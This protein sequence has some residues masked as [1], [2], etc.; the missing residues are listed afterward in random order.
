MDQFCTGLDMANLRGLIER[1][2]KAGA[3]VIYVQHD[4]GRGDSLESGT[5]GW[6]IHEAVAPGAG[7]PVIEKR[8]PDSFH[9]TGLSDLLQSLGVRRLV[10]TGLQTE[11]CVDTTCRRAF[12]LGFE[13]VLVEDGHSTCDSAYLDAETIVRH[14]NNVLRGFFVTL[15]PAEKVAF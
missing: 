15:A 14:H 6:R 2:E 8:T 7:V 10:V 13:V 3:P 9:G 1:A 4:G 5:P 12:I 11:Y